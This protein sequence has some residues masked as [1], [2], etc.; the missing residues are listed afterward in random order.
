MMKKYTVSETAKLLGYSTN[1]V[2][3]FL[4]DGLIKSVRIGHGKIRVPESEI[5]KFEGEN[6]GEEVESNDSERTPEIRESLLLERPRPG[7]SLADLS[8]ESGFHTLKLWLQERAG[9]PTLFDWLASLTSIILGAS[10][11]LYS[12]QLDALAVGRFSM[13]MNPIRLGLIL[14]GTGLILASMIQTE[15]AKLF[16]LTN[17]F[18]IFLSATYLGFAGI[19]LSSGDIVG[20]CIHGLFGLII[21]VEVMTGL[22]S[23]TLYTWYIILILVSM[24]LVY[25]FFPESSS[26]MVLVLKLRTVIVGFDWVV[27]LGVF[28]LLAMGV[29]GF[30]T[31]RVMMRNLSFVYGMLFCILAIYYGTEGNWSRAFSVLIAGLIG[32]I[33]PSWEE[34]KAK[35]TADRS[36]VFRMFGLVLMCFAIAIVS[37]DLVQEV[38]VRNAYRDLADKAEL[39][40]VEFVRG[41]DAALQGGT[42]LSK[43]ENFMTA[44]SKGQMLEMESFLKLLSLSR[45]DIA[46]TG[47]VDKVGRVVAS[48]PVSVQFDSTNLAKMEFFTKVMATGKPYVANRLITLAG[49][50]D[51]VLVVAVPV[52][53]SKNVLSGVMM[54]ALSGVNVASDLQR[55]GQVSLRQEVSVLNSDGE[56]LVHGEV[57]RVGT[58]MIESVDDSYKFI[59]GNLTELNGYSWSGVHS[60]FGASRENK[61]GLTV[62]VSQP[63]KRVLDVSANWMTWVL[64]MQLIVGIV[65]FVSFIWGKNARGGNR[66]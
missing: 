14:G 19:L 27:S 57:S 40:K 32:I 2:Y 25:R 28:V 58:K 35:L 36:L 16:N 42:T 33:L 66:A 30:L 7:K 23:A 18:R 5:E 34:F 29:Y 1:S 41:V 22:R 8:G 6:L 37:I 43:N 56:Y 62:T 65:V 39:A 52:A 9:F 54:I 44:F 46:M 45:T 61:Y 64:L 10:L 20:F 26:L 38:L 60:L 53:D 13:W 3:G 4:K 59:K 12:S 31:N 17:Y 50:I 24:L 48:Y 55:V 11:F 63:L 15:V 51:K 47:M 21:G 49:G